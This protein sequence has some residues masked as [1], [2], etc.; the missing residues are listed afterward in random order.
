MPSRAPDGVIAGLALAT[1]LTS[2]LF[3]ALPDIDRAAAALFH[4]GGQDFLLRDSALHRLVDHAV[5]PAV[6]VLTYVLAAAACLALVTRGRVPRWPPR[7]VASVGLVFA[8][9]PGLLVNGILK[10]WIGRARPKQITEFGGDRTFSAAYMPADEC[11]RNCSFVSGDVAFAAA[12]LALAL[13]APAAWRHAA[14]GAACALTAVTG[15]YRMATGAHFLSDIVLAALLTWLLTMV[16]H[17]T[18]HGQAG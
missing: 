16:V 1:V 2:G 17:R 5:R 10:T 7:A 14:V 8:L 12:L 6:K 4:A 13:L 9:G 18:I 11:A 15:F 3:V